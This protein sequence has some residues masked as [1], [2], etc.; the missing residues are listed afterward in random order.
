MF[1][2]FFFFF[3]YFLKRT[4]FRERYFEILESGTFFLTFE[5]ILSNFF[6]FVQILVLISQVLNVDNEFSDA[7]TDFSSS[8]E[9]EFPCKFTF[10]AY[11]FKFRSALSRIRCIL[12]IF[13]IKTELSQRSVFRTSLIR[14]SGIS[15]FYPFFFFKSTVC[16]IGLHFY[17]LSMFGKVVHILIWDRLNLTTTMR[18]HCRKKTA[19]AK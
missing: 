12:S 16:V 13:L 8:A 6:F 14:G 5:S 11:L 3:C 19:A 4:E 9:G 1:P 7:Q 15:P 18:I 17:E 10:F 2:F